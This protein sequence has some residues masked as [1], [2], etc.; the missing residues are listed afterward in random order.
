MFHKE[1]SVS[2]VSFT[3]S[4]DIH[5][6]DRVIEETKKFLYHDKVDD[7]PVLTM[8]QRELLMNAIEHGNKNK[9]AM[10]VECSIELLD[11]N[12][13][14]IVVE[15]CGNGFNY[16]DFDMAIVDDSNGLTKCGYSLIN[17]F[18]DRVEFS[19]KGNRVMVF[20]TVPN[21]RL[22]VLFSHGS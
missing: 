2:Q 4:S 15:D 17:A 3:I 19:E 18:S 14:K 16:E 8:V 12:Q 20:I 10:T 9:A 13:V 6:V 5:L 22:R 1:D 7:Y 21:E 11:K